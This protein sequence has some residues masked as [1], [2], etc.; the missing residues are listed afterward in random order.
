MAAK[1]RVN[2]SGSFQLTG[3]DVRRR[4]EATVGCC[5]QRMLIVKWKSGDGVVRE[6]FEVGKICGE[7][8]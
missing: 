2:A 3:I 1:R 4:L 5:G 8:L 6:D 7:R